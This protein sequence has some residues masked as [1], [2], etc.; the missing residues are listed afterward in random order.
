M[1]GRAT[2]EFH[3]SRGKNSM[4]PSISLR[5]TEQHALGLKGVNPFRQGNDEIRRQGT[6]THSYYSA[7]SAKHRDVTGRNTDDRSG[8]DGPTCLRHGR[9]G[10]HGLR[11]SSAD[12]CPDSSCSR[13]C[14][15]IQEHRIG[16]FVLWMRCVKNLRLMK[17]LFRSHNPTVFLLLIPVLNP[18]AACGAHT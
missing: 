8:G 17:R 14:K 1:R 18:Y 13:T 15:L 9:G 5:E 11:I 16:V 4:S 7:G 12:L 2:M 3:L 6:F 10:C